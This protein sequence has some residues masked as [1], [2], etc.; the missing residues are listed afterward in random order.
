MRAAFHCVI[1]LN[2]P[3]FAAGTFGRFHS[4]QKRVA[5]ESR[6]AFPHR[7]AHIGDF[8]VPEVGQVPYRFTETP[9][10]I[11]GQSAGAGA[12]RRLIDKHKGKGTELPNDFCAQRTFAA[13]GQ[14]RGSGHAHLQHAA[15]AAPGTVRVIAGGA[16]QDFVA[17]TGRQILEGVDQL[18]EEWIG[19]ISNEKTQQAAFVGFRGE[20]RDKVVLASR[21]RRLVRGMGEAVG[22]S[23]ISLGTA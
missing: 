12:S 5:A 16:D 17:V 20:A 13:E 14:N 15:D 7:P 9:A 10:I 4:G 2:Q 23:Q 8:P 18:W 6:R 19:Q 11:D 22:S 21:S 3:V 1:A